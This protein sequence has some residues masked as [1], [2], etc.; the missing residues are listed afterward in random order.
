MPDQEIAAHFGE[1][2]WV[3]GQQ[4]KAKAVWQESLKINPESEA[5]KAVIKRFLP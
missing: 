5:L 3:S 1:V 2:L 4:E